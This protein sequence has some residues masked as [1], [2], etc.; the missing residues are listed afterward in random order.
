VHVLSQ[1]FVGQFLQLKPCIAKLLRLLTLCAGDILPPLQP[2][3]LQSNSDHKLEPDTSALRRRQSFNFGDNRLGPKVPSDATAKAPLRRHPGDPATQ[4]ST[5]AAAAPTSA[6][7]TT[8]PAK[9]LHRTAMARSSAEAPAG[10]PSSGAAS[11]RP[12]PA[13]KPELRTAAVQKKGI[14]ASPLPKT[15]ANSQTTVP[16]RSPGEQSLCKPEVGGDSAQVQRQGSSL[17][18]LVEKYKSDSAARKHAHNEV[19]LERINS[20]AAG[21]QHAASGRITSTSISSPSVHKQ[22]ID[23]APAVASSSGRHSPV[24]AQV[25]SAPKPQLGKAAHS[26]GPLQGYRDK[27]VKSTAKGKQSVKRTAAASGSKFHEGT[28]SSSDFDND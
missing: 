7:V 8:V 24:Q 27:S 17:A 12:Q 4:Q 19:T 20:L 18:Q 16:A 3:A 1:L 9:P 6:A 22:V 13:Q 15:N 28:Q 5:A 11:K 23:A 25:A 14:S 21:L 10:Q 26:A 2:A